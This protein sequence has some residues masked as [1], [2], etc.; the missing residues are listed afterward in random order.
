MARASH[1]H[2]LYCK[3][4]SLVYYKLEEATRSTPYAAPIKP[5]QRPKDGQAEW[6][7]LTSQYTGQD[8]WEQKLNTQDYMLHRSVEDTEQLL[9]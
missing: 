4:N 7:S 6:L 9:P 2:A 1:I 3:D 8:K 5:F